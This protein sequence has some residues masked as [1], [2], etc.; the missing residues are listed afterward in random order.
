[1]TERNHTSGALGRS[2]GAG[3]PAGTPP[4]ALEFADALMAFLSASRRTRGRL[5]PLFDDISVPQLVLLD[6]IEEC[7]ADGVGAVADL[8]GL[9]QPTVTRS[10]AALVRDG[11]VQYS[12]VD[13]DGRRRVLELTERGS[14]LL[15]AKRAVVA[16]HLAGAWQNL[17]PA[18]QA[19]VAPL[20]RHL[21]ELVDKLF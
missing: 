15:A 7:G 17:S 14:T 2:V 13:G 16:G 5:Q 6:A 19:L 3:E 9:S 1:M 4:E 11:L 12:R 10:A 8:T 21:T 18:E 20:L